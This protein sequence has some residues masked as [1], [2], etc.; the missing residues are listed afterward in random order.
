MVR[1]FAEA[2]ADIILLPEI[3]YDID[4]VTDVIQRRAAADKKFTIIAVAEGA[5][6]KEDARLKKKEYKEKACK[7]EISVHRLRTGREDP[8]EDRQGSKDYGA[9]AI[10]KEAVRPCAYDRVFATRVGAAG[11]RADSESGIR[12]H[13]RHEESEDYKSTASGCAR[14][15]KW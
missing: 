2:G 13:D 10:R 3:P 9:G 12:L 7:T 4:V 5:I 8:A 14:K 6:S 1:A 15:L 11:G